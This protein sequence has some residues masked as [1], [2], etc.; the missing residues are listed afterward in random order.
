MHGGLVLIV[1]QLELGGST[2]GF[3]GTIDEL[4]AVPGAY[5]AGGLDA[6]I[7]KVL[8]GFHCRWT[9]APG[10]RFGQLS[11]DRA[12]DVGGPACLGA[13]SLTWP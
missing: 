9:F 5:L 13:V 2:L 3:P 10:M 1:S 4:R 11:A 8:L 7:S 6:A 12:G